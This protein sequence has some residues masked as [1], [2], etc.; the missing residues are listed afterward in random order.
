MSAFG[1]PGARE[2]GSCRRLG[3]RQE[4]HKGILM[5]ASAARWRHGLA[6]RAVWAKGAQ[7]LSTGCAGW[8]GVGTWGAQMGSRS[9]PECPAG[10][11]NPGQ[12]LRKRGE[13]GVAHA[14]VGGHASPNEL[15][16]P[17]SSRCISNS[18]Q[19]TADKPS[20]GQ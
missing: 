4:A 17:A 20:R 10:C 19:R 8:L 7:G 14:E 2:S 16:L 12:A 1:A 18:K 9:A 11:R 15:T 13:A 3:S 5:C 6:V